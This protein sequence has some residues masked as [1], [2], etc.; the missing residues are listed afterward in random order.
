MTA[1]RLLQHGDERLDSG[2]AATQVTHAQ[3]TLKFSEAPATATR[4][5]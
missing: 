5:A 1:Q 4:F 2:I 3:Q